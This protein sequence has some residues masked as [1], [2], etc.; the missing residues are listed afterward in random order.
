MKMK[1]HKDIYVSDICLFKKNLCILI[2]SFFRLY[3]NPGHSEDHT[4]L[5]LV[6]EN[7]IFSGDTILGGSTTVSMHKTRC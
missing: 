6:E 3:H 7:A 5:Q 4:I 2:V 1:C